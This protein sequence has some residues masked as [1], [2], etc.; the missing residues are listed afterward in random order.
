MCAIFV[1]CKVLCMFI[2]SCFQAVTF[3]FQAAVRRKAKKLVSPNFDTFKK[4]FYKPHT[5]LSCILQGAGISHIA[6]CSCVGGKKIQDLFWVAVCP[7]SNWGFIPKKK[8]ICIHRRVIVLAVCRT[9][10]PSP[11]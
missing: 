6:V 7:V 3:V 2:R 11:H 9:E 5:T 4:S 10:I 8:D 1:E